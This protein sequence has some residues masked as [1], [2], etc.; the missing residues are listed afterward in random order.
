MSRRIIERCYEGNDELRDNIGCYFVDRWTEA[1][2]FIKEAITGE[3]LGP[4]VDGRKQMSRKE[5]WM[6]QVS[7][8]L[9]SFVVQKLPATDRLGQSVWLG[10]RPHGLHH[11]R[12]GALCGKQ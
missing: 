2:T 9:F 3:P 10:C 12:L 8:S 1:W 11:S 5:P 4:T 7:V 6:Y